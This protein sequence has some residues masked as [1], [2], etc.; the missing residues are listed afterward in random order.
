[1][2]LMYYMSNLALYM[3]IISLCTD[4]AIEGIFALA[5]A[6]FGCFII[7]DSYKQ[8]KKYQQNEKDKT[9]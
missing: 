4:K 3:G 5:M 8:I 9:Q 6:F 1:M 7:A 2:Y